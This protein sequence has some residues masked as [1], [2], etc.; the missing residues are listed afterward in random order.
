MN[1]FKPNTEKELTQDSGTASTDQV[2][3]KA[4]DFDFF[5]GKENLSR[6]LPPIFLAVVVT[7]LYIS[8]SHVHVKSLKEKEEL[9]IELNELRSEYISAKS[10]LMKQSNQSEVAKRLEAEGVKELRT[11]PVIL[12]YKEK[13]N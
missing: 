12:E 10:N 7:I 9:K 2:I 11:P 8:L 3:Q 5:L 13:K 1:K 4:G 6:M